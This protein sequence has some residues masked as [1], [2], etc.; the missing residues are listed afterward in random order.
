MAARGHDSPQHG[1]G[2]RQERRGSRDASARPAGSGRLEPPPRSGVRRSGH[3]PVPRSTALRLLREGTLDVIGRIAE[4]SNATFYCHAVGPD[5]DGVEAEVACVYKPVRGE[6]PLWDF[7]VGTLANREYATFLVSE[8]SG[9][10]IVPPTLLRDGP[11][12]WGMVQLWVDVDDGADVVGL[13][14]R[15][16]DSL[17][18][19]ALFDAL[20]NNA[21][22]KGGH[23]LPVPGGHVHGV[24]HGICFAAEPKLR[25]ILWGWRGAPIRP[26]ERET[27]EALRA[28]L[29]A[30]LG[31]HLRELL[32][33]HEVAT[34]ARR[35]DS[36]LA[37][38][39][40]PQP[41]PDRPAIPWP[42]F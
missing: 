12:G 7:P 3:S 32:S 33:N 40:F 21:D 15:C 1:V 36:L 18:P 20:V 17:R 6:R 10:A 28:S 27:L 4:A 37:R 34:T 42:P 24:D 9:L 16:D 11:F 29:D 25:T 13:V 38:G 2:P 35:I 30:D 23:L 31:A 39:T 14:R 26:G 8:A 5:D 19:I 22:R 41:D